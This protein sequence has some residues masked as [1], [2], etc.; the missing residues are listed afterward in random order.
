MQKVWKYTKI[1]LCLIGAFVVCDFLF[2][3]HNGK[4]IM[5]VKEI[6]SNFF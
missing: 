2:D 5:N 6:F 4:V 1:G 3:Y